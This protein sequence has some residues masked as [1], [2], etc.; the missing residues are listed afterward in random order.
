[1]IL[2][3]ERTTGKIVGTVEGRVHD[4]TQMKLF[5]GDEQ[6]NDRL[7]VTWKPVR[8]YLED[9]TEIP[10][11]QR[12]VAFAADFEPDHDQK[13]IFG[14]ID[15]NPQEIKKYKVDVETKQLVLKEDG[16]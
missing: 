16:L 4:E 15:Q 6:E 12:A 5:V 7:I 1:M 2:F 9:G 11:S 14:Q 8:W 13:E 3:Y 10:K